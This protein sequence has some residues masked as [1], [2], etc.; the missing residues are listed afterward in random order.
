MQAEAVIQFLFAGTVIFFETT[1]LLFRSHEGRDEEEFIRMH[2]DPEVR[3]YVGGQ[4]WSR[5]KARSRFRSQYL[6]KPSRMYGLWATILKAEQK[7]VGCCGLRAA[8]EANATHLAYYFARPYW[9]RGLASEAST[10][11]IDLAFTRLQLRRLLAD[12]DERNAV[13]RHILGKFGFNVEGRQELAASGRV[14]L[15]YELRSPGAREV[16]Q[17][18][19]KPENE[20]LGPVVS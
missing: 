9:G 12:V 10:A 13:S 5:E 18:A 17:K 2:T 8:R 20:D 6:G 11:F 3:R 7:Y 4:A 15:R 19:G 14:I 16:K 1:R